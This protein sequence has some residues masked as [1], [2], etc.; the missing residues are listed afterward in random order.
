MNNMPLTIYLKSY[1]LVFFCSFIGV[2]IRLGSKVVD[3]RIE[4]YYG[5][6]DMAD[7]IWCIRD[8]IL[9]AL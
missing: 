4:F 2:W 9:L 6:R 1:L 3:T 7:Y 5:L 8:H